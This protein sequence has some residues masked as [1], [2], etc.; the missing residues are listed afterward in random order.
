MAAVS[1]ISCPETW[2]ENGLARY[3]GFMAFVMRNPQLTLQLPEVYSL[4]G[5]TSFNKTNLL[6][7]QL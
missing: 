4:L 3:D 6:F 5:A 2:K 7:G 1:S